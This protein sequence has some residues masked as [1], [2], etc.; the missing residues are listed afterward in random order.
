MIRTA[1]VLAGGEGTRLRPLTYKLPKPLVPVGNRPSIELVFSLLYR[2]GIRRFAMNV[3]YKSELVKH[4]AD[5]RFRQVF[6]DAELFVLEE[7][8]LSGTAGPVKKLRH[9]FGQE[10]FIVIGCDDVFDIDIRPAIELH[11]QRQATA[12]IVLYQVDDVS[13]YGVAVLDDQNRITGFQE[14]PVP[15]EAISNLAN[16][17]IYIFSPRIFDYIVSEEFDDFGTGV[18]HRLVEARER[19]YGIDLT[20]TSI[21]GRK[22]GYWIDIGNMRTYFRANSELLDLR[23]PFIQGL[24]LIGDEQGNIV[25]RVAFPADHSYNVDIADDVRVFGNA[26]IGDNT[27]ILPTSVLRGPVVIGPKCTIQAH[28]TR[29]VIWENNTLT[30]CFIQDSV[31]T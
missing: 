20:H 9:F 1:M 11:M 31:I 30:H 17:G 24:L 10:H 23:Y 26:L 7:A 16:T 8:K 27:R 13:Q 2:Y 28:L 12:T 25:Q 29:S 19:F 22:R 5:T 3:S 4:Y 15:E 18:F 6:P 21:L 14:K